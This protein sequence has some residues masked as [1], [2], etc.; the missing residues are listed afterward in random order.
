MKRTVISTQFAIIKEGKLVAFGLTQ[1]MLIEEFTK[2][3][4]KLNAGIYKISKVIDFLGGQEVV[5]TDKYIV[6]L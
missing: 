2:I 5:E 6:L 1:E 4:S 3:K